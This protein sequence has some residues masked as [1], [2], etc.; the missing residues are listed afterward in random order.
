MGGKGAL[1]YLP[2]VPKAFVYV[3]KVMRKPVMGGNTVSETYMHMYFG[4]FQCPTCQSRN[5]R[6][7]DLDSSDAR[8]QAF[9]CIMIRLQLDAFW[10][11]ATR[12]VAGHVREVKFMVKYAEQLGIRSPMP[13]LG[14]FPL[15]SLRGALQAGLLIMRSMEPGTGREGMVKWGTARKLRSAITVL[16]III[17]TPLD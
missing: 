14:P 1:N 17:I 13:K 5:I 2:I 15:G 6:G 16:I 4:A 12:T 8:D 7:T 3:I 11:H 9:E 10:S